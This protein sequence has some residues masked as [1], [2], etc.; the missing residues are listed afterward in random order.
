MGFEHT[1]K[2]FDGDLQDLTRLVAEMGGLAERQIVDSV[3]ALIRR[4]VAL[5][6]RVVAADTEIDQMQ[7]S[8][9]ERAVLTIARRQPM[10]IDLREIVGA[11]RVATDLERIGDLSKN[12]AK[13]VN[14]IDNDFHPLKLIRGLEHMTD[15]VQSQV[16][17]VLDAYTAHDLP[18]AMVVWNGDEEVDAICTS[19][20]RELLT[21]M[22]EDPRNI[23]FCIHLMFC[24]KNIERI[25]D[26]ATNIA[27]TVFYMIEGQ[28]IMD[29]RPKGDMTTFANATPGN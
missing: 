5:A 14:A 7:R 20:F 17:A 13:R 6:S 29:K 23:S 27:E 3:D 9:E 28:Q 4:D 10:A 1:T 18:A 2:A 24:A 26:H 12:I 21:Y 25:G 8:I 15:L 11:M 22:M 19:L 16:K